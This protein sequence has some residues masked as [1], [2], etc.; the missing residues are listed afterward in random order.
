M[1]SP[2]SEKFQILK[3]LFPIVKSLVPSGE[4][5]ELLTFL[6]NLFM[7]NFYSKYGSQTK[8]PLSFSSPI[9]TRYLLFGENINCFIPNLWP[10]NIYSGTF[11][12]DDWFQKSISGFLHI[13]SPVTRYL[14]SGE[15]HKQVIALLFGEK[16]Y[17]VWIFR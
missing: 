1:T 9:L 5:H 16:S 8:R 13:P 12:C 3:W 2:D 11:A 14:L 4:K 17:L 6:L 7:V 15:K 10:L